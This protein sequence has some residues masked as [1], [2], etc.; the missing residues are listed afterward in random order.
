MKLHTLL[1][2]VALTKL[3]NTEIKTITSDSRNVAEG[4]LFV[5]IKG[6]TFDGHN[7][8]K[9]MLEK[10]AT[11]VVCEMDLGLENQ[12]IV[13]NTRKNYPLICANWFGNPDKKMQIIGVTGTNGKTTI[14]TVLKQVLTACGHKVGL[15]GTSQNEIGEKIIHTERTTPE[16]YDLFELYSQM[17]SEG[18]EYVVMEVSSQALEQYRTGS[19]HFSATIFTNLTQDHLDVHGTMENYYQAKKKIFEHCDFGIINADDEAGRRY[20]SEITCSKYSYSIQNSADYYADCIKLSAKGSTFWFSNGQK[21]H[22]VEFSMPGYFN[23]SNITAVIACCERLGFSVSEIIEA[24]KKCNGVKGRAEIIPTRR[25]FT[26]MCDYAHTPDALENILPNMKNFTEGRLICLFGCGGNRD[27]KK[28][29][30]MAKSAA[31]NCDFMI[32]T[33]DNPRNEVPEEIIQDILVGLDGK[34]TPYIAITDRKEAIF[35]AVKNAKKGDVILLAGKGHEDYQVLA[36][37]VKIHFDEREI[38]AEALKQLD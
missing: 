17:A 5:C 37:N 25:D 8:A 3:P 24:L 20:F 28:R 38:V 22:F 1:H 19:T 32:I 27:K 34:N 16:P 2:G 35:Y 30:L 6:L 11:A 9:E 13:E 18:C 26:V 29:P 31:E 23:V 12:I 10:G 21:T 7:V 36:G 33:S 14:T 4:C 15:I